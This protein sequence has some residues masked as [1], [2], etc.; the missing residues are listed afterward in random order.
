MNSFQRR[1]QP[2]NPQAGFNVN[3]IQRQIQALNPEIR[4]NINYI[5]TDST[6]KPTNRIQCQFNVNTI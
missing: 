5:Q 6:I 2:L 4:F 1:Y 3:T